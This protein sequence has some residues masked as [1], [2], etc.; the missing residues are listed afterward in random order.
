MNAK[1]TKQLTNQ[2]KWYKPKQRR[3]WWGFE[4]SDG[5]FQ[6]IWDL[7]T[8]IDNHLKTHPELKKDF[9]P[10]QVKE[11]FGGLRFYYVGGDETISKYVEEAEAKSYTICELCGKPGE[12]NERGWIST[13]CPQCRK[14]KQTGHSIL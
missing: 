4:C 2:F 7:S 14:K 10:T 1:L 12:P 8:K 9:L 13:L 5:W 3:Q 11:K 6:L